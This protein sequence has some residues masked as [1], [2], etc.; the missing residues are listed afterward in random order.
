VELRV[1]RRALKDLGLPVAE[2]CRRPATEYEDAHDVVKAFVERRGQSPVGQEA[3]SLPVTKATVYNLHHGRYRCLTWHDEDSDV[4]WLLG[5]GWHESGSRDDAYAI[6]KARDEAGT[7]MP[8]EDDFL[9]LAMSYEEA[10]SFV[11]QVSEQAPELVAQARQNPGQEVRDLIAGR[12]DVGV[13]V[14]IVDIAAEDETLEEIWVGFSLPPL[15]GPCELP[16]QLEWLQT[17]L[18][19]MIPEEVS[20][21]DVEFGGAF[22]RQG[23]SRPNEVVACWRSF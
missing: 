21:A 3:T 20:L 16:A 10:H 22:P 8:D 15:P 7:L 9:D 23:G 11:A 17:V 6:L 12:L 18:A 14:E 5:V 4:V 19:A 13:Y 2:F 1:A